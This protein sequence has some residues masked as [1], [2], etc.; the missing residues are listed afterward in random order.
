VVL[1]AP[2][3]DL[4]DLHVHSSA[5]DGAY[6]PREVV[7]HAREVGLKAIALTD[8]DTVAGVAEAQAAGAEFG[9]EV[10]AGV[11]LSAEFDDGSCHLLGYFIDPANAGL[12]S[13]LAEARDGRAVRNVKILQRLSDLGF[14]LTMDEVT[15]RVADGTLGRPHFAMALVEKGY[16]AS[17]NEA[18]DKYL[19]RGKAAYVPRRRVG[20]EEGIQA[21]RAA[22]G[23]ASL[24]HPR[25][26]NRSV[27]ET[28]AWIEQL[29]AVGLEAVESSSPD[30]TANYARHYHETA[31]RLGLLETGGTDWH[32]RED[33]D[34]HLGLG[35]GS[36]L[37]HYDVVQQMKDRLAARRP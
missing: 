15:S 13:L 33:V 6:L 27:A 35:R 12:E 5:S 21:I 24:A 17:W 25:Q 11:E 18:F 4:V 37:I 1:K 10:I 3:P 19:G 30:H 8:H 23:L 2:Q 14:D 29:A 28:D 26:L 9:I 32:G 20:P 31:A 7:A 34:I 16:V 36:M 22:G